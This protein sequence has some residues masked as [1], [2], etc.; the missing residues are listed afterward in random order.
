MEFIDQ[1][2]LVSLGKYRLF[3][4][5]NAWTP[6]RFWEWKLFDKEKPIDEYFLRF[7]GFYEINIID[8]A[9]RNKGISMTLLCN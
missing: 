3:L 1:D 4:K 5:G 9:K 8:V 6:Q 7:R 2:D